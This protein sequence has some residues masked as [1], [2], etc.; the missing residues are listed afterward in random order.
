MFVWKIHLNKSI[1][2]NVIEQIPESGGWLSDLQVK[3]LQDKILRSY[4]GLK[5]GILHIVLMLESKNNKIE[6]RILIWYNLVIFED[7]L[8][9]KVKIY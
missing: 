1:F 4:D 5:M 8:L 9:G 6:G 7:T 2:K 3:F